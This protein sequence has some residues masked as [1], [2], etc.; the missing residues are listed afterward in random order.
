MG[1]EWTDLGKE[2]LKL[3]ARPRYS[4]S[5]WVVSLLILVAP[6]PRVLHLDTIR[7][8]HGQYLG[9]IFLGAFVIWLVEIILQI[10]EHIRLRIQSK[11]REKTVL[12][13]LD[14]LNPQE[15]HL[16]AYAVDNKIQTVTWRRD[17]DEISSLAAKGLLLKVPDNSGMFHKPCTIPRFVWRR[18]NT[19]TVH[20]H[21][22]TL[23]NEAKR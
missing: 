23:D 15:A 5:L 16:L 7:E 18:I 17:A 8:Q 3:A 1:A 12:E 9:L 20:A 2:F 19:P 22:K 21:L 11:H 10:S 4:F 14:S 6:L 13:H